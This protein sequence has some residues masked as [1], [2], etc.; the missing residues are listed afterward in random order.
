[1]PIPTTLPRLPHEI[2]V[3]GS[4]SNL[5][6][7][8]DTLSVAIDVYLKVRVVALLPESPDTIATTFA[9]AAPAGDNRIETA[10]RY[11]RE[12]LGQPAPGVRLEVE[13]DIPVRAG[14]GS[15]GAATVAGLRL[16]ELLTGAR[17]NDDWLPL[18][19]DVE[20]HPDN[21]AAALLGGMTLSCQDDDGRVTA[22]SWTW[23]VD[24]QFVVVTPDVPLE[25][26]FARRILPSTVPMR[27]AVFNLQRALLLVRALDTARYDDLGEALRDRWHQPFRAPHV[28]GLVEALALEHPALLGVCLSGAGPSVVA[29]ARR[30]QSGEAAAVMQGLYERLGVPHRVRVLSAHR[31]GPPEGERREP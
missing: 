17:T 26:A 27:D 9:G 5:G 24:V 7:A 1:M 11:A 6:P 20:G 14:L 4:I 2:V 30:R 29:L 28:P 3:P 12:R 25:T 22:R 23:P 18:A 21:V 10:F 13:S 19:R 15:S 31:A 16:Y 8:F